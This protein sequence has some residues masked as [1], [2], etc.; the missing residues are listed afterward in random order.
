MPSTIVIYRSTSGFTKKYAEWVAEECKADLFD[1]RKI[2][3]DEMAKYE[4][5][6][7]GGSLHAVG[8][9]GLKL[10]KNNQSRLGGKKVIVFAVGASPPRENVLT[11]V[12]EHNFSPEMSKVNFF[13]LRGGFDYNKLDHIN[14]F[15]MTLLKVRLAFKKTKS[16]DEI[17]MLAAYS[18]PIDCTRKDNIKTLVN[19]ALS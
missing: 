16:S 4:V 3:P 9:S 1:A 11:E 13:Y 2:S 5:V 18:K 12:R 8:I 17:G 7:F 10:I 14:K 6:I 19:C 15:L